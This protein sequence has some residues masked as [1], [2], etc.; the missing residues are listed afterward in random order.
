MSTCYLPKF[1]SMLETLDKIW[2]FLLKTSW[3]FLLCVSWWKDKTG[4]YNK[5]HLFIGDNLTEICAKFYGET[6]RLL[7]PLNRFQEDLTQA[8]ARERTLDQRAGEHQVK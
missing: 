8:A 4:L 6:K 2:P 7:V 1:N 5:M 3:P